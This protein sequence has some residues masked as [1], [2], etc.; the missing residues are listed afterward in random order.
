M[1]DEFGKVAV[2]MGGQSSEREISLL[3]GNA[4]LDALQAGGINAVGI[5]TGNDFFASIE[6]ETFDRAF[7]MLHG[8]Y[9][10]DGRVQAA[11]DLMN[12][13]YTGSGHLASALAM[14]KV[15]SKMLWASQGLATPAFEMLSTESNWQTVIERLGQCFVKPVND[16]SSL[17]ISRAIDAD[18]LQAAFEHALQ[19]DDA[20]FAEQCIEGPEYTV[21][22][23]NEKVLP[24]IELKTNN[25]F[26]D[27]AAKYEAEDTVYI[28]P[29]E[30]DEVDDEELKNLAK[31]AY[32]LV[33]C[34]GWGRVDLMRDKNGKFWLLEVNTIPGMTN[35]S[36]V[37]MSA[38][39]EGMD[40]NFLVKEILKSSNINRGS[41]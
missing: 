35:H 17:G 32:D 40:F 16:G 2:L 6:K 25:V 27:F 28:C 39:V 24:V 19:F 20:V 4:V 29:C 38:K 22:I 1:S 33:G 10:E 3:S 8:N 18:E 36:L 11:L 21:P 37:P 23:V 9:G 15:R 13:P 7:V 14:D 26:Y 5:D 30:L 41:T 34:Q 12:I 31:D